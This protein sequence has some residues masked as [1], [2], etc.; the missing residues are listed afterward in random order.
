[1]DLTQLRALL[2]EEMAIV[3][4]TL[5]HEIACIAQAMALQNEDLKASVRVELCELRRENAHMKASVDLQFS[6]VHE[7]FK[8]CNIEPKSATS[9]RTSQ[10]AFSAHSSESAQQLPD[11]PRGIDIDSW[12]AAANAPEW[13]LAPGVDAP[14]CSGARV[15]AYKQ[16]PAVP[17]K[18]CQ[19]DRRKM[20]LLCHGEFKHKR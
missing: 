12:N 6:S 10:Q 20:C 8:M 14:F 13:A 3:K 19:G 15:E 5:T 16:Q 4:E 11:A 1:M 9:T 7:I 2:K 17:D 18:V